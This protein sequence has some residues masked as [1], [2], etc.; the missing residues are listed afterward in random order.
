MDF[1]QVLL[2][3]SGAMM[4]Q[5]PIGMIDPNLLGTGQYIDPASYH[6]YL[7]QYY[8]QM[9]YQPTY[10]APADYG[11]QFGVQQQMQAQFD[12]NGN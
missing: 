11:H 8:A 4:Q 3:Q 7:Q 6:L 5:S 2:Q 10:L 1:S 9:G 12:E